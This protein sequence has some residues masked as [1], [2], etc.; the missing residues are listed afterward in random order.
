VTISVDGNCLA[1]CG[2]VHVFGNEQGSN[3]MRV[4]IIM[5]LVMYKDLYQ[6]QEHLTKELPES[7]M[8]IQLIRH[9]LC[10]QMKIYQVKNIYVQDFPFLS[11]Y[12]A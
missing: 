8:I 3:E 5:E 1:Y 7:N 9:L 10:T 4:S 2:S 11:C 6:T 12:D